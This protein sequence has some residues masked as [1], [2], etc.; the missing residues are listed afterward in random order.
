MHHNSQ[1]NYVRR[2]PT[3]DLVPQITVQL[4]SDSDVL[5]ST[6]LLEVT[7]DLESQYLA[8]KANSFPFTLQVRGKGAV[9]GVLWYGSQLHLTL[10]N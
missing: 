9:E 3:G 7:D 6:D 4:C 5:W 8:A 1:D 10:A 2:L